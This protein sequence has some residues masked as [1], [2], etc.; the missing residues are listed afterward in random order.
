MNKITIDLYNKY[1]SVST[2]LVLRIVLL[3]IGSYC[4]GQEN[5]VGYT[6]L[7]NDIFLG[8]KEEV[9]YKNV[10]FVNDLPNMGSEAF[11]S[12]SNYPPDVVKIY[13]GFKEY[14]GKI[15][16]PLNSSGH[17][18]TNS[19]LVKFEECS[20]DD[21]LRFSNIDFPGELA[22]TNCKFPNQSKDF[23]GVYGQEFG[24]ACIIDSCNIGVLQFL[25]REQHSYRFFFKL[26]NT[27]VTNFLM[28]ELQKST[29]ELIKSTIL[30][31]YIFI[32]LHK[33]SIARIESCFFNKLQLDLY[34]I[35]RLYFSNSTIS[36]PKN[37]FLQLYADADEVNLINNKF[38]A[39]IHLILKKGLINLSDNKINKKLALDINSI[40]PT[41]SIHLST[42]KN[43]NF[44]I[45]DNNKEYYDAHSQKQINDE[46]GY[47]NYLKINKMLYDYFKQIGDVN[48]ANACFIRIREIEGRRLKF[49]F[50]Q[51]PNFENFFSLNLNRLLKL[52]TN[53][54]TDP[55]RAIVISVYIIIIFAFLYLFFPSDWDVTSKSKLI[56][57]FKDF[58]K[59]NNKGYVRPF[60]QLIFGFFISFINALMLSLNAYTTLG[61]GNI[62]THGV[63]RY[64][65]I[66]QGFIGWFLLSVFTVALFNQTQF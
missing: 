66:I 2:I 17:F 29:S 40:D 60:F 8:N 15:G 20:F 32:Q 46:I 53:Y 43:L 7:A 42:L 11:V 6:Q 19:K 59:K 35:E 22:F 39:N 48:S 12:N 37:D 28:L 9:S 27:K 57:N 31:N 34:Q 26:N 1:S 5:K 21:D 3:L 58:V 14:L 30:S 4:L 18:F 13:G 64:L 33:E 51:H 62:P 54:G 65:C 10:H 16:A 50:E 38:D 55:S 49:L 61:F 44:G 47:R 45:I 36:F 23:Y 63:G 52:Y 41:S 25:M 24:G 56:E